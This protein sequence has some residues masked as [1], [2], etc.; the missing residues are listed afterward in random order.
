M[1]QIRAATIEASKLHEDAVSL[2]LWEH[3]VNY[4]KTSLD[5]ARKKLEKQIQLTD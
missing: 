3:S 2:E 5:H 1:E 4:L